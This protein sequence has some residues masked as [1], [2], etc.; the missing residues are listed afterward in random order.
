MT[1]RKDAPA[2]MPCNHPFTIIRSGSVQLFK[3]L[4]TTDVG[5]FTVIG[6]GFILCM[7]GYFVWL[8]TRNDAP[9]PAP[10]KR[11]S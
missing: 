8:F 2:G 1:Y 5:L 10:A 6:L 3:D 9:P 11:K 7:G 4:F